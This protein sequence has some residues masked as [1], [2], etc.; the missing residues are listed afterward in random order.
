M[1]LDNRNSFYIPILSRNRETGGTLPPGSRRP[2]P[3]ARRAD[4]EKQQAER[5]VEPR[6][7]GVRTSALTAQGAAT[8]AVREI[9]QGSPLGLGADD[10]HW[11]SGTSHQGRCHTAH[12]PS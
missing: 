12:H 3:Q 4:A 2:E 11:G 6:D 5:F 8:A 7:W 9:R 1:Q 10:Q